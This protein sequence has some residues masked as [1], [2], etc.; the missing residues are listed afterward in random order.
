MSTAPRQ[1]FPYF[2]VAER[3]FNVPL[4]IHPLKAQVIG[5]FVAERMGMPPVTLDVGEYEQGVSRRAKPA[6]VDPAIAVISIHGST[7]HRSSY[8]DAMSGLISY[9]EITAALREARADATV[10]AILL[11]VDSFGGEAAGCFSLCEEIRATRADKPVWAIVNEHAYSAGC[12]IA[13]SADRVYLPPSAGMGSIGVL[14]IHMDMSG[15]DAQAGV[16]YTPIYA[17]ARKIDYWGHAPLSDEAR[18][19]EQSSIDGLYELFCN[20]VA[21]GRGKRMTAA[22]ARATEAAC[23]QGAAAVTAGLADQIGTIDD[24]IRDLAAAMP[25]RASTARG[26]SAAVPTNATNLEVDMANEIAADNSAAATDTNTEATGINPAAPT[27]GQ[28]GASVDAGVTAEVHAAAIE[29]ARAE[30]HAAGK[31]EGLEVG[32]KEGFEA[33]RK[34]GHAAGVKETKDWAAEVTA[35]CQVAKMPELAT[36]AITQGMTMETLRITTNAA[37]VA[38]AA[39]TEVATSNGGGMGYTI[40]REA[41]RDPQAYRKAREAAAAAGQSVTIID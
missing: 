29:A 31:L 39:A 22:A 41:A 25:R 14:W 16:Q 8:M 28:P 17:G 3:M 36:A 19:A 15:A 23:Y 24:A 32:R 40:T 12:A 4:L 33:G 35:H 10:G 9:E 30:A 7:V 20:S 21:L 13:T 11:D 6:A 37:A 1:Q 26:R 27:A 2:R 38:A 5:N 18:A 34:E